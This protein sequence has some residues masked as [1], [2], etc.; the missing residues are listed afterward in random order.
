VRYAQFTQGPA[1]P[2]FRVPR[3]RNPA[4]YRAEYYRGRANRDRHLK[5]HPLCQACERA[6]AVHVHHIKP[7]SDGGTN[8]PDNLQSLCLKC[9]RAAHGHEDGVG[10]GGGKWGA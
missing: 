5:R 10:K 4:A 9:H 2:T 8:A 7:L 6:F 1:G 3:R